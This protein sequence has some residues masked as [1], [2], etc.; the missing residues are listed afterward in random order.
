MIFGSYYFGILSALFSKTKKIETL[1]MPNSSPKGI[2]V[3]D[4]FDEATKHYFMFSVWGAQ[5]FIWGIES[6]MKHLAFSP[7]RKIVPLVQQ[8]KSCNRVRYISFSDDPLKFTT[9]GMAK[10]RHRVYMGISGVQEVLVP[11]KIEVTF[12][13]QKLHHF[14]LKKY[15]KISFDID[16]SEKEEVLYIMQTETSK[17]QNIYEKMFPYF[18]VNCFFFQKI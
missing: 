3:C 15:Q 2:N 1:I 4:N 5:P 10:G 16:V 8:K 9:K 18:G 14:L 17:F 7:R 6:I 13:E 11:N 12:N